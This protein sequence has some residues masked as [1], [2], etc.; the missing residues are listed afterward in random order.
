MARVI[1][2]LL[3]RLEDH[4]ERR[5]VRR[6]VRG[7][8]ALVADGGREAALVQDLLQAVEDLGA[9]A[10]RLAEARQ[11]RRHDH[12]F[13]DVEAVVGVRAAIDD[14][15]HRHRQDDGVVAAEVAV[16]RQLLALGGG[17]RVGERHGEDRVR[18]EARLVVG[19]VDLAHAAVDPRLVRRVAADQRVAQHAVDVLH[20]V[21]HALAEVAR[22]VAVAQFHGLARSG[23][24]A[25]TAPRPG[26][27][28]RPRARRRPPRSGCRGNR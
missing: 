19:A 7:E 2:C 10:Q 17:T 28:C 23:R 16:Q 21:Q 22:G 13:L 15:H 25:R 9:A 12:E 5:L 20:R 6:Q 3:D 11:A 4:A 24:G 18:A 8:A 14:V 1:A 26:R 27:P